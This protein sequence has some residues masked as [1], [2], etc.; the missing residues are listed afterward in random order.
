MQITF[1]KIR[2]LFYMQNKLLKKKLEVKNAN[3]SKGQI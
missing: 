1:F 2:T 3:L